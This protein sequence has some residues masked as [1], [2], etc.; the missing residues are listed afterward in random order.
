MVVVVAT[1]VV[2]GVTVGVVV[3]VAGAG[4]IA[5]AAGVVVVV[6][7]A[8]GEAGVPC[9]VA[10]SASEREASETHANTVA[11]PT[12]SFWDRIEVLLE[13]PL[14]A[15]HLVKQAPCRKLAKPAPHAPFR[16]MLRGAPS[17]SPRSGHGRGW[18]FRSMGGVLPHGPPGHEAALLARAWHRAAVSRARLLERFLID[19][20][21]PLALLRIVVPLIVLVSPELY[22]ARAL[23]ESPGRLAF[24]P[25]G[26]GLIARLP[27][28]PALARVLFIVALSSAAT[29]I[30]GWWS[31]A[32]MLVLTLSAGLLFSLSQRQGAVLHDMHLFW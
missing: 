17:S 11:L 1:G 22:S 4:A 8:W 28:G 15:H 13:G 12:K 27:V 24:V 9:V 19:A 14:W 23:V 29:A 20:P 25:E 26:L 30:L 5:G 10:G 21:L 6:M 32:S 16:V 31:R 2:V 18:H 3:G 7:G